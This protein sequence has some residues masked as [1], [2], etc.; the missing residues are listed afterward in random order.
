MCDSIGMVVVVVVNQNDSLNRL[1]LLIYGE[2]ANY[3]RDSYQWSKRNI[4][5]VFHKGKVMY[6][7]PHTSRWQKP[8]WG[9]DVQKVQ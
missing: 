2:V 7:H 5:S 4:L 3:C 9:V 1:T 8:L 6:I